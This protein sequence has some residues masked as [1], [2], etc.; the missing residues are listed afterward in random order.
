MSRG[1]LDAGWAHFNRYKEILY[2]SNSFI[3]TSSSRPTAYILMNHI[4]GVWFGSKWQCQSVYLH[5]MWPWALWSI[6]WFFWT[7]RW[8]WHGP[9]SVKVAMTSTKNTCS[10]SMSF[11]MSECMENLLF[12][13]AA[14]KY[15]F[16]LCLCVVIMLD[17]HAWSCLNIYS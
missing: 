8:E 17:I 2:T 11:R 10:L 13:F 5:S 6:H 3:S 14:M 15:D 7:C 16:A 12:F 9:M 1:V 4:L